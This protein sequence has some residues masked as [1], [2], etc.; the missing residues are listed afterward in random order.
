MKR[1]L[2]IILILL[3]AAAITIQLVPVN[4]THPVA[5][6]DDALQGPATHILAR[7]CFDCHSYNT[8]WP[9]YGRIAP[10]SWMLRRHIEE[11][12]GKLNFSL[13]RQYAPEKQL[14]LSKE[15]VK[16]VEEGGMPL[17]IYLRLHP[18]AKI[19]PAD[20]DTLKAWSLSFEGIQ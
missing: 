1:S 4:R 7:S 17:P 15:A 20:L 10:V 18:E 8:T 16:E 13:W 9:W 2:V 3:A 5:N 12:R 11:G 14:Y 6:P 19:S